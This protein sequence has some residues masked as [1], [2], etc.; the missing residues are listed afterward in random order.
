MLFLTAADAIPTNGLPRRGVS[1]RAPKDGKWAQFRREIVS[2]DSGNPSFLIVGD[3]A[4]LVCCLYS[5]I[6][7][8]APHRFRREIQAAMDELC[9]GY[10][11]EAFDFS[12]VRCGNGK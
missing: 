9:P 12:K 7:G 6:G 5:E 8:P 10:K 2:G 1:S 4:I 11:L 3:E